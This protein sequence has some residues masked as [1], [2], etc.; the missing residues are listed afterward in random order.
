MPQAINK[1]DLQCCI[2]DAWMVFVDGLESSLRMLDE[3]LSEAEGMSLEVTGEWAAAI[4]HVMDDLSNFV[5]SIS[6]P[7]GSSDA[8]SQKI[9]GLRHRLYDYYSR[10]QSIKKDKGLQLTGQD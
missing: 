6:E 9:K 8:Y 7:R 2:N 5:F 10:F 1:D 3:K 4:D